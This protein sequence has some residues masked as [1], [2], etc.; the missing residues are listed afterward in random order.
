MEKRVEELERFFDL[1]VSREEKMIELK[2]EN[3]D[4]K[5]KLEKSSK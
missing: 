3:E 4:L 2:K 5:R 1:T